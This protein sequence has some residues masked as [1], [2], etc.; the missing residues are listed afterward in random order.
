[1]YW[2]MEQFLCCR[3]EVRTK[4]YLQAEPAPAVWYDGET[5][6]NEMIAIECN[7]FCWSSLD[8]D[9]TFISMQ[10][11][12]DRQNGMLGVCADLLQ[13]SSFNLVFCIQSGNCFNLPTISESGAIMKFAAGVVWVMKKNISSLLHSSEN[14]PHLQFNIFTHTTATGSKSGDKGWDG[15]FLL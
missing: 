10:T 13:N 4:E 9:I 15:Q 12:A 1:M 7:K 14:F 5:R 8:L 6:E 3:D 11:H 2:T